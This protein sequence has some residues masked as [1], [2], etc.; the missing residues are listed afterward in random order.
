[1]NDIENK[2]NQGG[3]DL[4]LHTTF[5]DGSSTPDEIVKGAA[6]LGFEVISITDHD[7]VDGVTEAVESGLNY[8]IEVIPGIEISCS[9]ETGNI[10]I[11]GY[12]I[13]HKNPLFLDLLNQL[14]LTRTKRMKDM[15]EKL[16]K[17][18]IKLDPDRFFEESTAV[19]IG[20]LHL[21]MYMVRKKFVGSLYEAFECYIGDGKPAYIKIDAFNLEKGIALITQN[22][23]IAV[24]AHPGKTN[25]DDLIPELVR[26][27]IRGIEIYS[28]AHSLEQICHYLKMAQEEGLLV[29]GGSDY[30]GYKKNN[31]LIGK[32]RVS[33]EK[34]NLLK[35]DKKI[36]LPREI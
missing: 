2:I 14:K 13:D 15:I 8:G 30:H 31:R 36:I 21:A 1:M 26:Y 20:R 11:L 35:T 28:P 10:H 27:G 4:H 34:I 18:G 6:K 33:M 25:R 5:S 7:T 29:T 12:F 23:G 16:N 17:S 22:G 3:A 32:I 24:Y 19:S 9:Y